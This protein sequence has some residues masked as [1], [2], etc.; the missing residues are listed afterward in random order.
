MIGEATRAEV[1]ITIP[2]FDFFPL[3]RP[4]VCASNKGHRKG[5]A[6]V[7]NSRKGHENLAIFAT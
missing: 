3:I 1:D 6:A 4:Q 7:K 2:P 5:Y